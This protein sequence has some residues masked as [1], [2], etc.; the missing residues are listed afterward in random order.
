MDEY[1]GS[2]WRHSELAHVSIKYQPVESNLEWTHHPPPPKLI[3]GTIAE[4]Q[5]F[6]HVFDGNMCA[7]NQ[8]GVLCGKQIFSSKQ[9]TQP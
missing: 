7:S 4:H 6:G 9:E 3:E 5:V 1:G 8:S 2:D